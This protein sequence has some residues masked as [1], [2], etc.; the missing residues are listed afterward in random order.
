MSL[1]ILNVSTCDFV[2]ES[3][4]L[5]AVFASMGAETQKK[6]IIILNGQDIYLNSET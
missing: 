1:S 5:I 4:S 3:D 2:Y 6:L